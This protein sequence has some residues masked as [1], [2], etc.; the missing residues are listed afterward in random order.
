MK[1]M[2]TAEI[3]SAFLNYFAEQ[4]HKIL[5]SASLVPG[6]DPTL[7]FTNAGMVPFKDIFIGAESRDY[8]RATTAQKCVRAGGKHNDLENVGY[9][10]RHHTFFEMMGNFSFGDYFK[11]DAIP[12]AWNLLTKVFEIPAEKLLATVYHEDEEAF[13]IWRDVIGLPE[14][15]IIR[16]GDKPGKAKYES[17]NFWAMGDTGPCGPCTEIFYDHGPQVWGGPPGSAEE[18]GD[19]FIEIWNIV[20]MQFERDAAGNMKPLPKPS[21][22]TGMGLERM[23]AVMQ[24]VHSN[25]EIDLFVNLLNAVAEAVGCANEGQASLKVIADHIRATV[26]LMTDGVLPGNEGRGYVLRR[27]MRRAIRHGYKLGQTQPFFHQLVAP[28]VKEMGAAYPEIA[29]AEKRVREAILREEQRFA[30]TL[31]GGMQVLEKDLA[32]LQGTEISGETVFKLYDTFGFPV[33][34]TADIA[35]ERN[36]TLDMAGYEAAMNRQRE[37]AKAAGKFHADTQ[38]AIEGKTMF[39]GYT[40]E[41]LRSTIRAIFVDGRA[42]DNLNHGDEAVIVLA[43]TPFYGES[44]GQV[45]DTGVIYSA[46]GEFLVSDT[47]KQGDNFLHFGTLQSG[48]LFA[49]DTVDARISRSRRRQIKRHHSATHLLHRALRDTLGS[50]VQQKGSLVDEFKTRFD[51]SH[52]AALSAEEIEAVEQAINKQVMANMAVS[53]EEMSY[54]AAREKGAMALF[55]EKYG[56]VVRVVSMG[57]EDYSIELCGGTHVSQTGDIGLVKVMSQGAVSAGVRRIECVAGEALLAAMR[58]QSAVLQQLAAQ[59]KTDAAQLPERVEH[60]QQQLKAAEKQVQQL[61]RELASGGAQNEA[62]AQSIGQWKVLALQRDGF[63]NA[64]LRD[65][66]DQLR[67]QQQLDAVVIGGVDGDTARLVIS[68]SKAAVARGLHAGDII[69]QLAAH[70]GGKGGGRPDFA[71]AGGKNIAGMDKALAALAEVLPQ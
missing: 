68:V 59:L 58:E 57:D 10:A 50:H 64:T 3:R 51:F 46:N 37:Q 38:Y 26:F 1:K 11:A 7:L 35:R 71:Q 47:Q 53:I 67:D 14:E 24:G 56:D 40:Q 66:A 70:I 33:D 19:R 6:N 13:G 42:V 49:G 9:T 29:E 5:H 65:S 30:Q 12:F 34:L 61:K 54:D 20:F 31:D 15:R 45:G 62:A 55:G 52:E 25:Y 23:T 16:I 32:T 27:I 8:K 44:G 4:E 41:K 22:D 21:I 36:L 17:D 69:R 43:E 60:L 28:L 63:D 48:Q 39:R 2:T 18:D